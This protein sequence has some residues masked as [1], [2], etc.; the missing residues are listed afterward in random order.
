MGVGHSPHPL[1]QFKT[2]N[3]KG[4]LKMKRFMFAVLFAVGLAMTGFCRSDLADIVKPLQRQTLY[5]ECARAPELGAMWRNHGIGSATVTGVVDTVY[6][7]SA[8]TPTVGVKMGKTPLT[9]NTDYT[10]SYSANTNVGWAA[11]KVSAAKVGYY[12]S[13]TLHF[14]IAP[15]AIVATN[16]AA[17]ADQTYTGSA[18]TPLPTVTCGAIT[19]VKDTDY[20]VFYENNVQKSSNAIVRVVGKGNWTGAAEK[21]FVI[22]D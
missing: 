7:G 11:V 12:G 17:I 5:A 3:L 21:K 20:T 18:V 16:I 15:K 6:T 14:F 10:V 19:L 9:L 13:Q 1:F 8:I 22:K 4:N 2:D